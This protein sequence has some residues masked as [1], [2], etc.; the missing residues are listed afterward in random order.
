MCCASAIFQMISVCTSMPSTAE[1][2]KTARSATASDGGD[3]AD[4]VGKAGRVEQVDLVVPPRELRQSQ[5][6]REALLA[7]LRVVIQDA[8]DA[9]DGAGVQQ[10][11]LA[12]HG[13]AGTAVAHEDDV[14][15]LRRWKHVQGAEPPTVHIRSERPCPVPVPGWLRSP[16]TVSLA[17]S[18]DRDGVAVSVDR[19]G[20]IARRT[21][22]GILSSALACRAMAADLDPSLAGLLDVQAEDNRIEVLRHRLA[23][24]P[25]REELAARQAQVAELDARAA[26]AGGPPPRARAQPEAPGGRGGA[27]ALEGRPGR[28]VAVRR[29][30]QRGPGAAGAAG[31][32]RLPAPAGIRAGGPDPRADGRARAAGRGGRQR[33]RHAARASRPTARAATVALAEAE[34]VVDRELAEVRARR[35]AAVAATHPRRWPATGSYGPRSAVP[36][37]CGWSAP[38]ARA[39]RWPCP[40]SRWTASAVR[41]PG[42]A[43]CEECGRLVVH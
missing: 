42:L 34:A 13:L 35:D 22:T 33:C 11:R 29:S 9:V 27:R 14:S 16:P 41:P 10:D 5:A 37:W 26:A 40:R 2:T 4:E 36:R 19:D 25:E 1:I 43:T 28:G 15:D 23:T 39:A 6:H 12:Q 38:A 7:L 31:R 18:A 30:G 24:L 32:G 20:R 17:V 3:L 21:E 8:T